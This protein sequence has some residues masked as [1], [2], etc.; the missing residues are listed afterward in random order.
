VIDGAEKADRA[1][2]QNILLKTL[3]EPPPRTVLLLV[4][5]QPDRLLPTIRS[6]CRRLDLFPLERE[7]MERLLASALPDT[8]AADRATL[9]AIAEGAP[10]QALALAEGEGLAMQ[11]EVDRALAALPG[12]D[13]KTLHLVAEA[14]TGRGRDL[15]AFVTFMALLR[16]A[17]TGAVRAAGRGGAAPGWVAARPLADWAAAWQRLGVLAEETERL[18][19]DRKQA[20]LTGLGWLRAG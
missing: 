15:E 5:P 3:E 7:E 6:R 8:P 2:V 11:A 18:N 17:L 9:A 19:L 12:L 16:R 13:G 4:T 14:V 1:E 20:V 10:G